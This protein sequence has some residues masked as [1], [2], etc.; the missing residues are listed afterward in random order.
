MN[1]SDVGKKV[2]DFAPLLGSVLGGPAGASIGA[3]VASEY[4]TSPEPVEVAKAISADPEASIKL[5]SIETA[6]KERLAEIK[7]DQAKTEIADKQHAR[8]AHKDAKMPAI[9]SVG[10]TV[11][12]ALIVWLLFYV[13]IP[14][15]AKEVL[16]ML[17]GVVVKE[18]GGSMQY[19]FGT[20]RSSAEKTKLLTASK[21]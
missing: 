17:L 12:I 6:H 18:W 2:A 1:W 15:G 14:T 11:L 13:Q 4:G 19:W 10:L 7:L 3:I 20:T 9:L 5:R 21:S 8:T 16:Y